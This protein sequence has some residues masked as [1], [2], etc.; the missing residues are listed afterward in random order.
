MLLGLF[1]LCCAGIFIYAGSETGFV[2]W[3]RLKISFRAAKGEPMARSALFLIDHREALLSAIL[4]GSNFCVVAAT[5]L[6]ITLYKRFDAQVSWS[7]LQAVPSPESWFFS[8][9]VLIFCE[10]L[11]KSLFRIYS[12]SFTMRMVPLLLLTYYMF[13]PFT[14]FID[15]FKRLLAP[16]APD[17]ASFNIKVREDM[18]SLARVGSK[19]GGVFNHANTFIENILILKDKTIQEI[20]VPMPD[21]GKLTDVRETENVENVLHRQTGRP[22]DVL[23]VL[24]EDQRKISGTVSIKDMLSAPA[25]LKIKSLLK[26]LCSMPLDQP[27]LG[28]FEDVINQNQ[29][30]YGAVDTQ[31]ALRGVFETRAIL[32]MFFKSFESHSLHNRRPV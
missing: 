18:A 17:E 26:P 7:N 25:G 1:L 22:D 9:F 20:L 23:L 11:P 13:R 3:N 24:S 14:W 5:I 29:W 30:Y 31:G 2:S 16:R 15:L 6:F 27:L 4:I 12:F 21:I 10:M 8:P 28:G 19:T 32:G